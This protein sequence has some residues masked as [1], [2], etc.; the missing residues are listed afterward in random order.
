MD[1]DKLPVAVEWER[2]GAT[3]FTWSNII[4]QAQAALRCL[5]TT[6]D[7]HLSGEQL[8]FLADLLDKIGNDEYFRVHAQG[9][10]ARLVCIGEV[11]DSEEGEGMRNRQQ[12]GPKSCFCGIEVARA[13]G[14]CTERDCPYKS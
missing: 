14:L 1:K 9:C 12:L 5:G 13:N 11:E 7:T 6:G 2:E 4:F 10:E 8:V 3:A